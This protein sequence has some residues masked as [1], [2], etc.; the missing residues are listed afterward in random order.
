MAL[1]DVDRVQEQQVPGA[2]LFG[3]LIFGG[4]FAM[5]AAFEFLGMDA[6]AGYIA[7]AGFPLPLPLA[8]I[9]GLLF[10]EVHGPG[11]VLVVRRI[12]TWKQNSGQGLFMGGSR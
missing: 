5:A 3:R 9:A 7:A 1:V 12:I 10:A 4:V 2:V 8:W 6:T 11:G